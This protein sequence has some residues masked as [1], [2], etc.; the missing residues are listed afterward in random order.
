LSV[1]GLLLVAPVF[2]RTE[3]CDEP[4]DAFVTSKTRIAAHRLSRGQ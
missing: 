4:A 3:V 1:L 2:Q